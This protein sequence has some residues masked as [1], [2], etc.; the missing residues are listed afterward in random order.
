MKKFLFNPVNKNNLVGNCYHEAFENVD[1]ELIT[2][3]YQ[4]FLTLLRKELGVEDV[5]LSL[6]D[7]EN[8]DRSIQSSIKNLNK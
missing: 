4:E 2:N 1:D 3:N 5:Y 7:A 6:C 8:L